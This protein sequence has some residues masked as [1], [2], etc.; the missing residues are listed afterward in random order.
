[1]VNKGWT[2]LRTRAERGPSANF[3]RFKDGESGKV[4]FLVD[5]EEDVVYYREHYVGKAYKFCQ[6]TTE[7]ETGHCAYC[8][9]GDRPGEK[10]AFNVI[11]RKD[12]KVKVLQ[13]A[14]SHAT[15]ILEYYDEYGSINDRDYKI[16]RHGNESKTRYTFVP[17]GVKKMDAQDKA[18]A[19]EK[20]DLI[21][22]YTPKEVVEPKKSEKKKRMTDETEAAPPKKAKKVEEAAPKAKKT[23][24]EPAAEPKKKTKKTEE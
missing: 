12:G 17:M 5:N 10:Y 9:D 21:E 23:P 4:R 22:M 3:I 20:Y 15:Q 2:A 19:K 18:L 16:T 8:E 24:E 11:D 13:L 7:D 6:D 1:M 14:I